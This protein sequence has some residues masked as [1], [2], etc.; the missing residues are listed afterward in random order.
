MEMAEQ[1]IG[2]TMQEQGVSRIVAVDMESAA[3]A[4]AARAG[5]TLGLP[6]CADAGERSE[7]TIDGTSRRNA[8]QAAPSLRRALRNGEP[9][10]ARL[11]PWS[12]ALGRFRQPTTLAMLPTRPR[13][14]WT[15]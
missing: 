13:P 6:S 11:S 8:P 3:A 9:P 7:P 10:D 2:V 4:G 14:G 5:V 15:R 12:P 1:L